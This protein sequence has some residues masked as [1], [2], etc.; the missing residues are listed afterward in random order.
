MN[1]VEIFFKKWW[2]KLKIFLRELANIITNV[3]VPIVAIAC[4]ICE[5]VNAPSNVIQILKKVEY[6][7]FYAMGTAHK[8][9]E[10]I[11]QNTDGEET[12]EAD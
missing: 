11:E 4:G 5:A 10:I 7:L 12:K 3:C 9:D 1:K 2:E 8:I 6:W